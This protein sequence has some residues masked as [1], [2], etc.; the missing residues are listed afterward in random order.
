ML[1]ASGKLA[2]LDVQSGMVGAFDDMGYRDGYLDL[3]E[4]DLLLLYTDGA[5]EARNPA[6]EFLGE[7]GLSELVLS[8]AARSRDGLAGRLLDDIDSYTG[9]HLD[10]DVALVSLV[11]EKLG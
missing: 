8:E 3:A 9:H 6:R 5:T 4:G 10:D 1:R 7:E 11:F 2:S